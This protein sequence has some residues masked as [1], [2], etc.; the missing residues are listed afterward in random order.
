MYGSLPPHPSGD[1]VLY[2]C[3]NS[4]AAPQRTADSGRYGCADAGG[5]RPQ[6]ARI[7]DALRLSQRRRDGNGVKVQSHSRN[8]RAPGLFWPLLLAL[9]VRHRLRRFLSIPNQA[10]L[11]LLMR[12][13][14]SGVVKPVLDRTYPLQ[15]TPAAL[16]HIETGHA[17]GKVVVRIA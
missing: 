1:S 9:F 15:E 4:P 12:L 14:E 5:G 8:L 7:S 6:A 16:R 10:D 11:A 3:R 17:R 2:K 13:L